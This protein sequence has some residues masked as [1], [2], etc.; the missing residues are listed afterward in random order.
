[1]SITNQIRPLKLSLVSFS[2][3]ISFNR[4]N[5]C[6]F[7]ILSP[8]VPLDISM[9]ELLCMFCRVDLSGARKITADLH[10]GLSIPRFSSCSFL[11][12]S[13]LAPSVM[14]GSA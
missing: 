7:V 6:C 14:R 10:H 5:T 3:R 8:G 12:S 1:M 11:A 9:S 4:N 2:P 13:S